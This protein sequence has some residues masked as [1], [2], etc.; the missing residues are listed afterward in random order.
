M[1]VFDKLWDVGVDIT[2][3]IIGRIGWKIDK[4]LKRIQDHKELNKRLFLFNSIDDNALIYAYKNS[5]AMIFASYA[6][7]FGLPIIE[8][9]HYNLQVLASDIEIHKEVGQDFISYFDLS[10]NDSLFKIIKED[11][12][13]RDL[14]GFKYLDW[15]ESSEQLFTKTLKVIKNN[16]A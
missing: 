7:G 5:K 9:I 2:Y 1:N 8:S 4:L 16:E 3:V 12:F 6:E 11:N 14:T 15:K 13:K 10:H